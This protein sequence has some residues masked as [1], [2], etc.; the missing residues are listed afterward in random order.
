MFDSC[1]VKTGNR[2]VWTITPTTHAIDTTQGPV[3]VVSIVG[4]YHSGK[5]FMLNQLVRSL[6]PYTVA[7]DPEPGYAIYHP[8]D[9][10][11]YSNR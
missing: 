7:G 3:G 5:S 8:M 11:R 10:S 6:A 1:R 2:N 9:A 4:P